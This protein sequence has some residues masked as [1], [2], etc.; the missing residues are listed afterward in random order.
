MDIAT[1]LAYAKKHIDSIAEHFDASEEELKAALTEL[2]VY[3]KAKLKASDADR[4]RYLADRKA[5]DEAVAADRARVH[6]ELTAAAAQPPVAE[7]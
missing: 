6:T 3:A 5:Q 4:T 2:D 7:Q 1:K